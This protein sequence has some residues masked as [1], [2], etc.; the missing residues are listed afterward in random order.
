MNED[1]FARKYLV[2]G[3]LNYLAGNS[4]GQAKRIETETCST[5]FDLLDI[6][7]GDWTVEVRGAL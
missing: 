5:S 3:F 7:F 6:P 4:K 1:E 2:N